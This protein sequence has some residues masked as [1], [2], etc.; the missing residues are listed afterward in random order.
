MRSYMGNLLRNLDENDTAKKFEKYDDPVSRLKKTMSNCVLNGKP[1]KEYDNDDPALAEALARASAKL[2][3][4]AS[5]VVDAIASVN[6]EGREKMSKWLLDQVLGIDDVFF[7]VFA[8][9]YEEEGQHRTVVKM[10]KKTLTGEMLIAMLHS[11]VRDTISH[12]FDIK[13]A[14]DLH[15][16]VYNILC[17]LLVAEAKT[18][19]RTYAKSIDT[20]GVLE[21]KNLNALVADSDTKPMCKALKGQDFFTATTTGN[22]HFDELDAQ[23]NKELKDMGMYERS[24]E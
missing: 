10:P 6:D 4:H 14:V 15:T 23:L 12:S 16:C 5:D 2:L 11:L 8:P 17:M 18:V 3:E 20:L 24:R 21:D 13:D 9:I 22:K 1:I 19:A 7:G